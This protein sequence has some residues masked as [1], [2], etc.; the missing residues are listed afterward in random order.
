MPAD[1]PHFCHARECDVK[2]APKLLMC[3]PHWRKVPHRLRRAVWDT[4]VP[5]QEISK[6]PSGAYL[7]AAEAAIDAVARAEGLAS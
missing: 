5:G 4:Y 2:V 6:Q 3:G 1:S 7:R